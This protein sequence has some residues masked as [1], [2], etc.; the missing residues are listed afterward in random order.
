MGCGQWSLQSIFGSGG[1][2]QK[3]RTLGYDTAASS[4]RILPKSVPGVQ[5]TGSLGL[6]VSSSVL[7]VGRV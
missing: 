4:R 7:V 3:A 5:I 1:S 6:E 2:V